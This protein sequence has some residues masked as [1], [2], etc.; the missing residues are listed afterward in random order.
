VPYHGRMHSVNLTLPPLGIL[1]LR[2]AP[3][4]A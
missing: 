4:E 2:H 1:I 3:T